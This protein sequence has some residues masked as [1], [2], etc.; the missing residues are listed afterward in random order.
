MF[1]LF[2]CILECVV[3]IVTPINVNF[4]RELTNFTW[5]HWLGQC[6]NVLFIFYDALVQSK[7]KR[8]ACCNQA[9]SNCLSYFDSFGFFPLLLF[10]LY[11][12]WILCKQ[13]QKLIALF[14]SQTH[15]TSHRIQSFL[16]TI[17]TGSALSQTAHCA[18][19]RCSC[20]ITLPA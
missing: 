3:Y 20:D 11:A 17:H 4:C 15:I 19:T 7:L 6:A 13:F 5:I 18:A 2:K 1:D 10:F 14:A 12:L 9:D 16:C 8:N